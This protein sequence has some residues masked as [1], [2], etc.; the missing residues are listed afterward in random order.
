MSTK[1]VIIHLSMKNLVEQASLWLQS[2]E[3]RSG[4]IQNRTSL[5]ISL[6]RNYVSEC[7]EEVCAN[8]ALSFHEIIK[9][10][11]ET[12]KSINQIL[13]AF[14]RGNQL[15]ALEKTHKMMQSMKFDRLHSDI[16]LYKCRENDRLFHYT[17]D[18]MFHIP[19]SKRNLVGNQRYSLS[20]IPCL[21]VG[22]SSYICWEE[23]GRKDLSTS[24]YCGYSLKEDFNMFD[25]LLP[26]SISNPHQI[27]RIVLILACS[28][29]ADRNTLFKPEYILPQCILHS[30]IKRT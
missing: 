21:Y 5:I 29:A 24:N 1:I 3:C 9:R 22:G 14:L 27:R 8:T 12:S 19:Y 2:E 7:K 20:G 6:F 16:S 17:K 4:S 28:L 30:L 18:E 13:A 26:I 25:M 15:E 23:L 11:D 10:I